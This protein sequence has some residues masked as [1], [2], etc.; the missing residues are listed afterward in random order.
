MR[1]IPQSAGQ[2]WRS[3]GTASARCFCA[4]ALVAV[5]SLCWW[6]VTEGWAQSSSPAAGAVRQP[7]SAEPPVQ[8]GREIPT[9][10]ELD[11]LTGV[12]GWR[13]NGE[14]ISLEEVQSRAMAYI[15]PYILR[16]LVASALLSQEAQRRGITVTDAE[17]QAKTKELRD[18]RGLADDATFQR[19]LASQLRTPAWFQDKVKEYVLLEKVLSEHVHVSDAEVRSF[20]NRFRDAYHRPE[21]VSYRAMSFTAEAAAQAAL[22][23]LRKGRSF[24]EI[25]KENAGSA[26]EKS[27]AGEVQAYQRGQRPALPAEIEDTLFSAPLAQV[28]GPMKTSFQGQDYYHLFKVEKRVDEHQTTLEEAQEVI[29]TELRRRKLEEQ[30]YPGWLQTALSGASIEPLKAE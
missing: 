16:D 27:I 17:V 14:E 28:V 11:K 24:Q 26:F 6:T 1:T 21:S 2:E 5:F 9:R 13:V 29:R 25:A 22:G 10:P 4:L 8:V 19:Y 12:R 20:Y 18:D 15:G 23:E 3:S 30:V 7:Q